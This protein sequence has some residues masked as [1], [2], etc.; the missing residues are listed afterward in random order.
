MNF[1]AENAWRPLKIQ[2]DGW[3]A[4]VFAEDLNCRAKI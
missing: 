3:R 1:A 4:N 2:I